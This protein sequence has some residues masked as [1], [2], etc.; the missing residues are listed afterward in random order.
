MK[1]KGACLTVA[2]TLAVTQMALADNPTAYT[3]AKTGD[4]YVGVQSKD[5]VV[6]IRSEKS[7][8]SKYPNIWYVDYYDPDATLK[9]VEVKFGGGAEMEVSHPGRLIEMATDA[10]KPFDAALLKVDSDQAIQIATS[11]PL[12]KDL[13]VTGTQLELDHGEIGPVW[14]V[15]LWASRDKNYNEDVDIGEIVLSAT[16]G[17]IVK[18]DLHPNSV[19]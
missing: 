14:H 15:K 16:D 17:S 1:L 4:Q 11:Q 2:M 9:A 18:N 10:H 8:N 13:Y 7:I 5:R 6:Q 3:L 19:N 12:L